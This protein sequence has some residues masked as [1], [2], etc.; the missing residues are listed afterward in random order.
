MFWLRQGKVRFSVTNAGGRE[1]VAGLLEPGQWFGETAVLGRGSRPHTAE[2]VGAT[3]LLTVSTEEFVRYADENLCAYRELA[4]LLTDRLRLSYA[5]VED[6]ALAQVAER[7]ARRLLGLV[8]AEEGVVATSQSELA[9]MVGATREAVG[10]VLNTWKR[11]RVVSVGYGEITVL[12]R[13]AL[14]LIAA[15]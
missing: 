15:F 9:A 14:R 11:D 8:K 10:R 1:V 6:L 2:A 12:Y 3:V 5:I 13:E 7:T 4:I